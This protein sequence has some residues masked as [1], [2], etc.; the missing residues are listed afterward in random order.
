MHTSQLDNDNSASVFVCALETVHSVLSDLGLLNSL[1][2]LHAK[3]QTG[4]IKT[5]RL[6][7][8]QRHW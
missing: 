7:I 3:S 8:S 5:S 4:A 6:E 1:A 2:L